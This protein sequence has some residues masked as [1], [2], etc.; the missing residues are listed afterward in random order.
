MTTKTRK[1]CP[2]NGFDELR[3][4][5]WTDTY[6]SGGDSNSGISVNKVPGDECSR[7]TNEENCQNKETENTRWKR[8][9]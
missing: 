8:M 6:L 4:V 1:I 3:N 2:N 9:L 5:E 7:R